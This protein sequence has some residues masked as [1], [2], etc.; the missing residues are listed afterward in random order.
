MMVLV[1]VLVMVLVAAAA[2]IPRH[3]GLLVGTADQD[4]FKAVLSRCYCWS[5]LT[6]PITPTRILPSLWIV[7]RHDTRSACIPASLVI[8]EL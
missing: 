5:F 6:V 4:L 8:C 2:G 7:F 1:L 3:G